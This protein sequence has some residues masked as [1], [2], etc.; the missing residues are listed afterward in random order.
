M[1]ENDQR[2]LKELANK[3]KTAIETIYRLNYPIIQSFIVKN[4]GDSDEAKDIFQES[5]IVLYEKSKSDNFSLNC[6]LKT[7]IYSICRRLWLKRLHQMQRFG[8]PAEIQ[9][10]EIVTIDEEIELLEKKNMDFL[11]M[12]TA[13]M[14]IGEPC[15][16]ILEAYYLY[17]KNMQEIAEEF[18]YTNADNAKTQK[19]KCLV[20]L[21]KLFFAQ[22]KNL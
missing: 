20:R 13:L 14:K 3:N 15:K 9:T 4:G 16:S 2:L 19:Y 5:M 8:A 11:M 22:H 12:E 7:Y 17:K 6:L 21:K 1:I 10:A 18:G